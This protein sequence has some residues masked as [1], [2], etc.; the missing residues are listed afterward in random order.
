MYESGLG[1]PLAY[2]YTCSALNLMLPSLVDTLLASFMLTA[3]NVARVSTS[4]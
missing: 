3:D 2:E 1:W 4:M